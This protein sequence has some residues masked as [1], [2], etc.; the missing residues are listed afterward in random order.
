MYSLFGQSLLV[1]TGD[2]ELNAALTGYMQ[3]MV[4][5]GESVMF[6]VTD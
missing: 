1:D 5:Y 4:G 3:V 6:P 2:E